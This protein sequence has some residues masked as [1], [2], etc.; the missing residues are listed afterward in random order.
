MECR[1]TED[2]RTKPP[3]IFEECSCL[4]LLHTTFAP[5]VLFLRYLLLGRWSA[6]AYIREYLNLC[7]ILSHIMPHLNIPRFHTRIECLRCVKYGG[8]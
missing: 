1:D 8:V 6:I 7:S 2:L 5:E 4:L 3:G